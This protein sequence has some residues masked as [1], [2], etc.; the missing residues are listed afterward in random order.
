MA[1]FIGGGSVCAP[2]GANQNRGFVRTNLSQPLVLS[3]LQIGN[4]GVAPLFLGIRVSNM[5]QKETM[6]S[7]IS[8]FASASAFS[9]AGL[10]DFRQCIRRK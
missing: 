2:F 4:N 9:L 8:Y 3:R 6:T 5:A 7:V 10:Q 1:L